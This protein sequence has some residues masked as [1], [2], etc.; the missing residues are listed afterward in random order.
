MVN[1]K[2][3][4]AEK[5]IQEIIEEPISMID[6]FPTE[7]YEGQDLEVGK[8]YTN[9]DKA[10]QMVDSRIGTGVFE[11]KD[12]KAPEKPSIPTGIF[13]VKIPQVPFSVINQVHS[14]LK[15][16]FEK[17][18]TEVAILLWY[19]EAEDLWAIE[20]PEQV[21]T[22]AHVD[23]ERDAEYAQ[24][25]RD[26][27]YFEAGSIHSHANMSAFHSATDDAD[28]LTFDGLHMTMGS[29]NATKQTFSQRLILSGHIEKLEFYQM[30]NFD[31]IFN[32]FYPVDVPQDWIDKVKVKKAS[33]KALDNFITA[34]SSRTPSMLKNSKADKIKQQMNIQNINKLVKK[35]NGL[36]SKQ[37][38][39]AYRS[40][41][42]Y[43]KAVILC[44]ICESHNVIGELKCKKCE[45][46]LTITTDMVEAYYNNR[47]EE[48]PEY[49]NDGLSDLINEDYK[50]YMC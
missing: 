38:R 23:Y 20:V 22:G 31:K 34:G 35:I 28:E 14:F 24:H 42:D 47:E 18:K 43:E 3:K 37:S 30:V 39:K 46:E 11:I 19:S 7:E 44:P 13:D 8:I 16:I 32:A 49:K 15:T 1:K 41:I 10:Y 25:M 6:L 48:T 5:E 45:T 26:S 50:E 12:Y 9:K 33:T 36:N 4:Q 40:N 21:C 27:G 29:F 17:T 2:V